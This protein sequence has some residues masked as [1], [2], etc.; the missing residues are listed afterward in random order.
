M[1]YEKNDLDAIGLAEYVLTLLDQ[2]S[3]TA[4]YKYAVLL[5]LM[6]LCLEQTSKSGLPPSM[7]TTCQLA[8]KVIEI[9]WPHTTPF[10]RQQKGVLLQNTGVRQSQAKIVQMIEEFRNTF[11]QGGSATLSSAK[12]IDYKGYLRLV[13]NVE[14]K[15]IE[16]PLPRL[17]LFG[18]QLRPFLYSINWDKNIKLKEVRAYQ[19]GS[20]SD[21]DNRIQFGNGVAENL[22]KL[23]NLL[24]PLIHRQWTLKVSKINSLPESYLETFL[25]GATRIGTERVRPLLEE[26][27]SHRCFYC[28]ERIGKANKLKPEVDHFIPWSRYPENGLANL[29]VAHNSCNNH[30]RDFLADAA[31]VNNWLHRVDGKRSESKQFEELALLSQW[32]MRDTEITGVGAAIYL[33]LTNSSE[34]W[35]LKS[36]FVSVDRE[37]LGRVFASVS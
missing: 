9:Y 5:A 12:R 17:Q 1:G 24:R 28:E 20:E 29:V 11:Q 32:E 4:T 7:I 15:L 21:F 37:K 34:L 3:F 6:D 23:N 14:W 30:K 8:E 35:H 33:N 25:F 10:R 27:Q 19:K 26:F 22:C 13:N 16:M 2:G 36:E 31:H 18:K